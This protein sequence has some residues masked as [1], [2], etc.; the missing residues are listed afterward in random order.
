M[1]AWESVR[2]AVV[3]RSEVARGGLARMLADIGHVG[4]HAVFEPEDFTAAAPEDAIQLLVLS[5]D[6]LVLWCDNGAGTGEEAWVADL[7]A[8]TRRNGIRV[9]LMLPSAEVQRAA[10]GAG[11]PHDAV[12]DRDA[13]TTEELGVALGRLS[14]GERLA[15]QA[16]PRK[17]PPARVG[18]DAAPRSG[19]LIGVLTERE[20]QVL[21][22]LVEGLS[23]RQIGHALSVSEH[24]AKRLVAIVL[25]KLNCPNRTQAVA[26]ALREGLVGAWHPGSSGLRT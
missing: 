3:A 8:V 10:Y 2:V 16:V 7:A 17:P 6:V 26:V 1:N 9:V 21:E 23:N 15:P 18:R 14:R 19:S 24:A 12:L 13:L 22:L 5:C 11:V 20:R 25:S 4:Q